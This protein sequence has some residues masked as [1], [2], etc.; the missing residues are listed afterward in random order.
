MQSGANPSL[1]WRHNLACIPADS[2]K[3]MAM[4]VGK[5]QALSALEPSYGCLGTAFLCPPKCDEAGSFGSAA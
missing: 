3:V 1:P 4:Q 5:S 2:S